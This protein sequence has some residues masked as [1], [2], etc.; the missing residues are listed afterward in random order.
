VIRALEVT[1]LAMAHNPVDVYLEKKKLAAVEKTQQDMQA[2]S[3]WQSKP[4]KTNT[5]VLLGRFDDEI[6]KRLGWWKAENV[7]EAAFRANLQKNA[8]KAFKTYDPNRGASLRTHVNNM[9]RRSQ[10]FN[11]TYQ[12]VAKI[13]EDK[14]ALISPIQRAQET[15]AQQF[16]KPPTNVAIAS[17]LNK[18]PALVPVARVRGKVTPKLVQTVQDYQ[19]RDIG[20]SQFESDPVP[21]AASF[22]RET[23]RLVRHVLPPDDRDIYDYLYG[24]GGK[25]QITSTSEIAKRLGKS[26]SAVSRA[27]ARIR[28]IYTTHAG[29]RG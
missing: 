6:N 7:N 22:G 19:I 25:P 15:L 27:K 4:T 23:L 29:S 9:L 14:I 10:R 1:N 24:S 2:F 3:T 18:H 26:P 28:A 11:A 21:Q 20:E 16:D 13:P 17:Y 5:R 12:N 8:I